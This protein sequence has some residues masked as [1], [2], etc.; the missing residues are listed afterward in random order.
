MAK[1]YACSGGGFVLEF[2]DGDYQAWQKADD[3][4]QLV[5]RGK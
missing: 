5:Q 1:A 3:E 4:I 2:D